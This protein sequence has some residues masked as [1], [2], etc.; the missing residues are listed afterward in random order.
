[1]QGRGDSLGSGQL[2]LAHLCEQASSLVP[3]AAATQKAHK[4]D[5]SHNCWACKIHHLYG[6]HIAMAY[7]L[8]KGCP[9]CLGDQ[10]RSLILV[11]FV[12]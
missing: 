8:L 1:M 7:C 11:R 9:P 2:P 12:A 5:T 6:R 10:M 4:A 3:L